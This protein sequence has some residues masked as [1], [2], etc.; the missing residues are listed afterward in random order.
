MQEVIKLGEGLL[1]K[2]EDVCVDKKGLIYTATKD[3]WIRR[4]HKNGSWENWKWFHTE[5]LLGIT[6]AVDGSIIVCDPDKVPKKTSI[7]LF[8]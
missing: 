8:F 4:L 1:I 3:G 5:T 6:A 2:P 7:F